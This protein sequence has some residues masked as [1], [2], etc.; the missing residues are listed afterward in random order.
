MEFFFIISKE[1]KIWIGYLREFLSL[2]IANKDSLYF[3]E[4]LILIQI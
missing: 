4:S 2:N 3:C 1:N